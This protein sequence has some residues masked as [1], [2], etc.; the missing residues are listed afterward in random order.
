MRTRDAD[1]LFA[2]ADPAADL[3]LTASLEA[4]WGR[5]EALPAAPPRRRRRTLRIV[6]VAGVAAAIAAAMALLPATDRRDGAPGIPAPVQAFAD[7]LSGPGVLHVVTKR[8][9]AINEL[10]AVTP[11]PP[12]RTEGWY[13]LDGSA[14][15]TRMSGTTDEYGE[16]VFD[17]STVRAFNSTC[18]LL[19]PTSP[20]PVP[21]VPRL[22]E[23]DRDLSAGDARVLGSTIV[24]GTPAYNVGYDLIPG[25]PHPF[26]WHLFVSSHNARLLR[27]EALDLPYPAG[28]G[29]AERTR[30]RSEVPTFEILPPTR[31]S[32]RLLLPSPE[33]RRISPQVCR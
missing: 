23:L 7:D 18:G 16:Q 11:L 10:G 12:F 15:R 9:S 21:V 28:A 14:W 13:A 31:R 24:R 17:G 29:P 6:L 30:Q 32:A 19:A 3:N 4:V 26:D 20:A 27:I 8:T 1:E 22:L 25:D 2:S 5:L 33:L